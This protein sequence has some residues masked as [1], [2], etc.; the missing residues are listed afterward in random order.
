[1]FMVVKSAISYF[2]VIFDSTPKS[3]GFQRIRTR[4]FRKSKFFNHC[5][6]DFSVFHFVLPITSTI[7]TKYAVDCSRS[8]SCDNG[9][10]G[11]LETHNKG[12]HVDLVVSW[13]RSEKSVLREFSPLLHDRRRGLGYFILW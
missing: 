11:I 10:L 8:I 4:V 9:K 2:F 12:S 13:E 7:R 5:N 6:F 3:T 1:M